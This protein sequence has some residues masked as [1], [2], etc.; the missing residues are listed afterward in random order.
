MQETCEQAVGRLAIADLGCTGLAACVASAEVPFAV[1]IL[2]RIVHYVREAVS[3]ALFK[4][5]AAH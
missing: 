2:H 4:H 5:T 1:D 3:R